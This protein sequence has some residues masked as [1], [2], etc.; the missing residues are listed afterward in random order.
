MSD[1][2]PRATVMLPPPPAPR[3]KPVVPA[4]PDIRHGVIRTG[5][6]SM[7]R[8]QYL[9]SDGVVTMCTGTGEPLRGIMGDRITGRLD[10]ETAPAVAQRL[11]IRHW[12]SGRDDD[13]N[14]FNRVLRYGP[15]GLV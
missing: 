4:G 2:K 8:Y 3:P 13:P 5:P 10:G 14:G 7:E 12:Q 6:D 1:P 9:V 11:A 15:S